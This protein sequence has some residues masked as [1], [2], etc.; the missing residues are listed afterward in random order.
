MFKIIMLTKNSPG[1]LLLHTFDRN[2]L[3]P[4]QIKS[5][6]ETMIN[7]KDQPV[8]TKMQT[9]KRNQMSQ[10][11]NHL[12]KLKMSLIVTFLLQSILSF[13]MKIQ[14]RRTQMK[15]LKLRSHNFH[16]GKVAKR[17][18]KQLAPRRK[19]TQLIIQ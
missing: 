10:I 4:S 5:T 8:K 11:K 17:T 15:K 2:K 18:N 13:L 6:M 7:F 14:M 9:F 12:K 1:Y 16:N 3:Y 19:E